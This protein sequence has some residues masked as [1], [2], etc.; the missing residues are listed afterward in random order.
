MF[1]TFNSK[2]AYGFYDATTPQIWITSIDPAKLRQPGD[3]PSTAPVWLPFQSPKERNYQGTWS[4]RI[5]CSGTATEL[6]GKCGVNEM[7][8]NGACAMVSP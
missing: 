2:I 8:S 7:C 5:G 6:S 1:L 4:E 3:D